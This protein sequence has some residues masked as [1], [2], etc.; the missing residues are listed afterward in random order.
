[1]TFAPRPESLSDFVSVDTE[2][3]RWAVK[4]VWP[5][6]ASGIIGGRPKDGKSTLAV[7]L[8]LSLWSGTP[9]FG[10]E[11]F[12]VQ[13][14]PARVLYIQAENATGR[15]RRDFQQLVGARRLGTYEVAAHHTVE[16]LRA[17]GVPAEEPITIGSW[18]M[19]DYAHDLPRFDVLN[20]CGLD[21]SA[22]SNKPTEHWAWLYQTCREYDYLFLDPLY[23]LIGLTDEKDSAPLKP[24][25]TALTQIKNEVDCSVILTHH[26][27]DKGAANEAKSLLGSTYIHAWYE[28][29]LLVRQDKGAMFEVKVDAQRSHGEQLV[30]T[31]HGEGIG[32][33][34]YDP[35]AQDQE[36]STG[37][38][39]PA[40]VRAAI[41]AA[42]LE[43]LE[44]E[45]PEW[46]DKQYAEEL[47]VS[48]RTVERYRR[49]NTERIATA[50]LN[51]ARD[52][53]P[54]A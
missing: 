34:F 13:T 38:R 22:T 47:G 39:S 14:K 50:L 7:E 24:I 10:L 29:A 52:G 33:W 36:D 11:Q 1:M 32:K 31:L 5:E 26:M 20:H 49:L 3:P 40:K 23:M 2:E 28:A 45:N 18:D 37:R 46:E 15:V 12:P 44:A 21:L 41:A 17:A 54:V 48:V 8:A 51:A 43:N 9:M 19:S 53:E 27:S 6:G 4:G 25:L 16:E 42:R 35:N 30:H